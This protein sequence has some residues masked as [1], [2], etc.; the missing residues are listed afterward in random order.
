MVQTIPLCSC[1]AVG[2]GLSRHFVSFSPV[3]QGTFSVPSQRLSRYFD[4][5]V[6]GGILRLPGSILEWDSENR[7]LLQAT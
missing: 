4:E 7:S 5:P 3:L 2:G 6:N 1:D